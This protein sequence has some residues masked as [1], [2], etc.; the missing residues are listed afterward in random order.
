[1]EDLFLKG[2]LM[3]LLFAFVA[4][5]SGILRERFLTPA[6]GSHKAHQLG[7][8]FVIVVIFILIYSLMGNDL[9]D[10]SKGQSW[11]L[12]IIWF[13]MTICFEFLFG[14]Y[15]IGHSWEHLLADYNIFNGKLWGIFLLSLALLPRLIQ[16]I[17]G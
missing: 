10:S 13:F 2:L 12:G 17:K 9:A 7:T 5:L 11:M 14:Y 1:M 8:L 15:V 3:W 6:I 4:I 16:I